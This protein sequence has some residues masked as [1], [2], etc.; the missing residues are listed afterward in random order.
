MY[1]HSLAY[2]EERFRVVGFLCVRGAATT[3]G[4]EGRVASDSFPSW[5]PN[6]T[7]GAGSYNAT[8]VAPSTP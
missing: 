6:D 1:D 8:S 2:Q 4:A 3:E 5:G 7:G